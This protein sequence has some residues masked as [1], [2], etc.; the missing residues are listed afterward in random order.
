MRKL[1]FKIS[2]LI[3]FFLIPFNANSE[4]YFCLDK[5]GLVYPLFE[6][7]KCE[8][9]LD[10]KIN[11]EEFSFIIEFNQ[12]LRSAQLEEY[13]K[14]PVKVEEETE[15]QIVKDLKSNSDKTIEEKKE[16]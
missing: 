11:K 2:F 4:D 5:D 13:R 12:K 8:N 1:I 9:Q 16:E 3:V 15:K 10:N 6:E 14:N 7:K